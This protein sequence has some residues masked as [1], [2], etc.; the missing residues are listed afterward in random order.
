MENQLDPVPDKSK[1]AGLRRI[2][3][4]AVG[5]LVLLCALVALGVFYRFEFPYFGPKSQIILEPDSSVVSTLDPTDLKNDAQILT[6]RS[7][8]LGTRITFVVSENNQITAQVPT[9]SL[10]STLIGQTIA[11][12]L[13]EIVDFGEMP[14]ES[15]T[16]IA[17]DYGYRYFP[18]V[19][20]TRW[21]TVLTNAEFESAYVEKDALGNYHIPFT[22][23]ARGTNIFSEYTTKNVGHYL[24]IV[25]DKVVLSAPKVNSP[26]TGGSGII[27]GSFTRE[28]A[29]SL[30]V[31]LHVL[32]PLP[33]PLKV[34][35]I[36]ENGK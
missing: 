5:L 11:I 1:P 27:A 19:D 3:F 10:S 28:Q 13:L 15:G 35:E 30:A 4:V 9:S 24:G 7:S 2:L 14:I 16:T 36:S 26:I 20:G 29:E 23:T 18:Q 32:G 6:A 34:K 22:L 17:T 25:L 33:I 31:Y 12:G 21:H 8:A